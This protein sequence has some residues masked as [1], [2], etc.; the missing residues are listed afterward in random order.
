MEANKF[1]A[2][3][4]SVELGSLTKAS[5]ELGYTQAGLTHMM[6]RLEKE[7]GVT[8]L[9]RTKLGVRL[10]SEGEVLMPLIKQFIDS[11][12]KLEN[13]INNIIETKNKIIRIGAYASIANHWLPIIM[14]Q[15]KQENAN[16]S[17]ELHVGLPDEIIEM[18]SAG[19]I[20]V[21]FISK[22]DKIK[23]DW[24]HLAYDPIYA[25]LPPDCK[26]S[27]EKV[28]INF[29]QD[30]TLYVPTYG[31]DPDILRIIRLSG[32]EPN[33]STATVDDATVVS[34]VSYG[35]GYGILTKLILGGTHS[36]VISKP[37]EP[38]AYRE[39]GM[40]VKSKSGVPLLLRKFIDF[41]KKTVDKMV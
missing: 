26:F 36:N 10:T 22:M 16:V 19:E 33:I 38:P 40:V 14:N 21:G 27:N 15:F 7:I 1:Y 29:F 34:M 6:N 4:R 31:A 28:S 13:E 24:V 9:N 30:K 23:F 3:I 39:L 32:I 11:S 35:L 41:S 25:V 12:M 18:L 8:I 17:F 20:D 5:E 37:I 2:L